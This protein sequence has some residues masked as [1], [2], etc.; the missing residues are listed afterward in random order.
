MFG[1]DHHNGHE[2]Q[3]KKVWEL[4]HKADILV[5]F[6]GIEFDTKHL[7]REWLVNDLGPPSPWKDVDLYKVVKRNFK[8]ASNSLNHV[9]GQLDLPRKVEHEGFPLW[10]ACMAGDDAAWRRMKRYQIGDITSTEALYYH[11]LPWIHNHPHVIN[12][13]ES[14]RCNRCGQSDLEPAGS[15]LAEVHLYSR[16]WCR[17]CKGWLRSGNVK[18]ISITR[19]IR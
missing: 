1:S 15:Y 13:M 2:E 4:V 12:D 19:G 9:L 17:T 8:F 10:R 14:M 16:Y 7:R 5:T 18:R 3:I 11:L 6:N